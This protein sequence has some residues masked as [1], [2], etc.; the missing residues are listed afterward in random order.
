MTDSHSWQGNSKPEAR[1]L[2]GT[3]ERLHTDLQFNPCFQSDGPS[4]VF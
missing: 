3:G 2:G 1:A 4:A